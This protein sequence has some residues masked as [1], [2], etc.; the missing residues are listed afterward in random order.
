M[1]PRTKE[2]IGLGARLLLAGLLLASG[3]QKTLEP[4]GEFAAIVEAYRIIPPDFIV[5]FAYALPFAELLLGL[6]L[7]SGCLL[8]LAAAGSAALSLTF[9]TALASTLVRDISLESCGCFGSLHLTRPQAM[10]VDAAM[11]FLAV[12]IFLRRGSRYSLDA[13]SST[14]TDTQV[15]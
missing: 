6:M 15:H 4:A 13:W 11:I 9:F 12:L 1:S 2:F 10:S 7:L 8:P 3:V 5:P 14:A